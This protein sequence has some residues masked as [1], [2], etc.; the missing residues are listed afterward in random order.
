M[1]KSVKE[2]IISGGNSKLDEH[3]SKIFLDIKDISKCI[4]FH[5]T[6]KKRFEKE[7]NIMLG[8]K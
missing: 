1:D 2:A 5:E 6:L 8:R 4:E 3:K 7:L